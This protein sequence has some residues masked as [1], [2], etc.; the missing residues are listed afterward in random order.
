MSHSSGSAAGSAG[1]EGVDFVTCRLCRRRFGFLTRGHLLSAH[2]LRGDAVAKYKKRYHVVRF[3][4]ICTIRA[5]RRSL[6]ARYL[7]AGRRW[8]RSRARGEIRKL[9]QSGE[10][11]SAS[12]V[13]R[14]D[15]VI[16]A[17]ASRAFG[18]WELALKTSG[19]DP[20]EVRKH[21]RWTRA[22]VLR[23]IRSLRLAELGHKAAEE[24]DPALVQTARRW[25]GDWDSAVRAAG[26]DPARSRLR[27]AWDP[28]RVLAVI[29]R[30][31]R[32]RSRGD[33]LRSD[34]DLVGIAVFYFGRWGTAVEAA[35][36]IVHGGSSRSR[37]TVVRE[38]RR[39]VRE[40]GSLAWKRLFRERPELVRSALRV[41]GSWRAAIS[42]AGFRLNRSMTR[43]EWTRPEILGFL[44]VLSKKRS[45][46]GEAL[47]RRSAPHGYKAPISAIR[48]TFGSLAAAL[49]VLDARVIDA[50]ARRREADARQFRRGSTS[51]RRLP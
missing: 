10:S 16:F 37:Q 9:A 43:Q 15:P 47:V 50:S 12:D 26:R 49:R 22:A 39:I 19:I 2:G 8:T 5:Q 21:R 36:L 40:G 28:D 31:A 23:A 7:Q 3:R 6:V 32:G 33:V 11:L 13:A 48:R 17:R 20:D 46:V 34:P 4:S 45:K 1:E 27:R 41:F 29:N 51:R 38:I 14:R 18:G 44:K 42:E 25:F 35:K 24:R 30:T